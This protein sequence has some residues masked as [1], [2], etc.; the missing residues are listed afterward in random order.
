MS[1]FPETRRSAIELARSSDHTVRRRAHDVIIKAYWK[2]VYHYLRLRPALSDDKAKDLTQGFFTLAI[3][4]RYF[5]RYD[6]VKGSFRT[7]LRTCVDAFVSNE[8]KHDRRL[9][10]GGG[11]VVMSLDVPIAAHQDLDEFFHQEWV[12]SVFGLAVQDVQAAC[13]ARGKETA[14]RVFERY[15]LCDPDS[16][17]IYSELAQEFGITTIS[18][19]NYLAAVRRDLRRAVL[20]KLRELTV[21]EREFRM[22]AQAVLGIQV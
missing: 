7:Y 8:Q 1:V 2:P 17:P 16:R 10:R 20:D 5:D 15:D 22:E 21:D 19:T 13:V 6:H 11:V 9:K 14:F 4:K 18:L 3:E 12:R